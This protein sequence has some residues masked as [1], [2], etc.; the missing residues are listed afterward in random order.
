MVK[1]YD[2]VNREMLWKILRILGVPDNLI[3]VLQKLYTD[4]TI[5]LRVG[6][7]LEQ[8]PSASGVKQGDNLAPV[9]FI[10]VIH[11]VSNSQDKKWE[12]KT[13]DFRWQPDTLE[14]KARGQLCGTKHFNK[15]T[16]F[17]FFKSYYVDDTAFILLGRGELVIASK[18]LVS[19]FRRL[20]LTIHT[21][22]RSKNEGSKTEAIHF[23]T[24]G[25]ELSAADTE[26]I[27]IDDM[28]WILTFCI[29][30]E[31]GQRDTLLHI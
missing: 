25:Q 30:P 14:G 24:S 31:G 12:F 29:A 6:E 4:V 26:D 13:P 15:G 9:L 20:G 7:K 2:T 23:P 17:L 19:H 28:T 8:F 21:G 10:F 16:K 18:L 5:N 22:S 27:E 1:D 3:E 11:V